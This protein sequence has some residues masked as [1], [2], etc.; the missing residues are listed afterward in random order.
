MTLVLL[1]IIPL[2]G[3]ILSWAAG[4]QGS[5]WP[6]WLSLLSMIAEFIIAVVLWITLPVA[7]N[8]SDHGS[9]LVEFRAAWFPQLG[10]SFHLATDGISLMLVVLT[11]LLGIMAIL[12]SWSEVKERAGFFHF[13]LLFTL[14]GIIGVFLSIDLFLFYFFWELMLLP[15]Y[16]LIAL[17]GHERRIYAAIKFFIFTQL[18]GLF[19][20]MATLGLVFV[21]SQASE[22]LSF[23]YMDLL[24][25][26][27]NPGAAMLL[28][29]GFLAAFLVKLPAIPVHTWLP[30]AHTE[31]PTAGSVVLAGLLL[32]TGAYGLIRFAVPLFPDAASRLAPL[33]MVL[34]VIGI[35]YGAA[36]AF[37]QTDLKRLIAYTS[38]SHMGFVLLGISAGNEIALQGVMIQIICHGVSTGALFMVAGVLQERI[39]TRELTRMGGLWSKVPR[40]GGV[41]LFFAL[42]SL[43]LPGLG[44]FIGEF[45]VLL[46]TYRASPF[47][48]AFASAGFIMA[49]VYSVWMIW[50]TF[51]GEQRETWNI[52]DFSTREMIPMAVLIAVIVWIGIFPQTVI[53]TARFGLIN[54]ERAPKS[55][56]VSK[57][58]SCKW[59]REVVMSPSIPC[60]SSSRCHLKGNLDAPRRSQDQVHTGVHHER[61]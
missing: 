31:A 48:A 39:H 9:W 37:A 4:W 45:L 14:A 36:L 58:D 56:M 27:M 16:F 6:R 21:H 47:A 29:M 8:I 15:M 51:F 13:N 18:G 55:A 52:S 24:G 25:T 23:D 28:L 2:S 3:G 35:I 53:D 57:D 20:L 5:I 38:I 46:G 30:D 26:S 60:I 32:K 33:G 54:P 49:T 59:K 11:A 42:A 7:T 44:N 17:W 50:Q 41:G 22:N 40:M 61:P 12:S 19:M 34:G 10:I 1:I 43:G